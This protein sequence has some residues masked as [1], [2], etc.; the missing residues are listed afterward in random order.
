M[1][2]GTSTIDLME[3]KRIIKDKNEQLYAH[4]FDIVMESTCIHIR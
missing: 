4:I 1:K 3:V 2:E